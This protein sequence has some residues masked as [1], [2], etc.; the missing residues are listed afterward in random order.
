MHRSWTPQVLALIALAGVIVPSFALAS[1]PTAL[2]QAGRWLVDTEGRAVILHGVNQ[3]SKLP[4]YLPS[5]IGFGADDVAA[6]AAEG[7]N[8]VR[9]GLAHKGF[10]PAPGV[11]DSAYLDD[12]E[13]TIDL[14]T[15]QG[16]YVMIDFHQDMYNERYQGNGMADWMTVDSSPTDP[17]LLPTCDNGFPGNIFSCPFLWEAFDR[18]LGMNGHTPEIGPRA[19][20]LQEEF[21]DAWRPVAT[22]FAG[23]P[24]V[25]GYNL[26]NEPYPG[27]AIPICLG[28]GGCPPA[29]D[30]Q[31][32]TFS[33]LV[34]D[35]VRDVDPDTIVFYEPFGTNFNAG[36]PTHHGD[37]AAGQV[38]FSFHLYA[39]LTTPGP[40]TAPAA[41]SEVCRPMEQQVFTNA[42]AQATAFGHV[43]LLTE[44]GATDDLPSLVRLADMADANM[45]GWQYWAWWNRDPC[46]ARDYENIIDDPANPATPEHLDQPKLDVLVRPFP[47]AVAG[48]PTSWSWD[49][50]AR[51]FTLAYSTTP[52]DGPLAPGAV[53]EVWVPG[54]H[55]P[56]GYDVVDL[57]GGQVTS[58]L[59]AERLEVVA[60][61]GA[62]TVSFAVVPSGC[63]T[64][65]AVGCRQQLRA[66]R[67]TLAVTD[68]PTNDAK[69]RMQW[70]WTDGAATT[71]A[72]FGDP[73]LNTTHRL[74]VYD[75]AAGVPRLVASTGIGAAGTCDGKP[76]WRATSTGFRYTDRSAGPEGIRQ[77]VLKSGP[78]GRAK[79]QVRTQGPNLALA[80]LPFGQDPKV[81]VQLRNSAG[82]C[83]ESTYTQ[84]ANRNDSER[85]KDRGD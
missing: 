55:F 43:P 83:W 63:G 7:F 11:Y 74:C 80:P 85:F 69:D 19:I 51:R 12:L 35:A 31:L 68:D 71:L 59:H 81:T 53:T 17:T 20:T 36:F 60:L 28:P 52:V 14:M 82:P 76:C 37:V 78:S 61:P 79:I 18:F 44:W 5:A 38:G 45:M 29:A 41:V 24:L 13:A 47:R 30:A 48:T 39:C 26:L 21:A 10:V 23:D 70:S 2:H 75:E 40:V 66:D 9:T 22:R 73:T 8:T 46:C 67:G 15:A 54:R 56:G 32:T 77:V 34:A 25:F 27:S 16:I 58:L 49:R 1:P 50:A 4:P 65:P 3:V 57:Q 84:P 64:A 62:T 33:N 42:E 6:I 72:D